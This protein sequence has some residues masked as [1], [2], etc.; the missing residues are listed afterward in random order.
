ML[1]VA[2]IAEEVSVNTEERQRMEIAALR[3]RLSKLSEASLRI[4]ETLDFDVVLQ[5]VA[6]SARS[7][8]SA[9]YGGITILDSEGRFEEFR[10]LRA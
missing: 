7:L 5:D 10:I 4:N 8:S 1:I 2:A 9:R 3:E 6:D